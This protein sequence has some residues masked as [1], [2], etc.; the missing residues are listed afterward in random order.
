MAEQRPE[1]LQ[2]VFLEH[3]RSKA[4]PVT[5]FLVNGIK[6]QGYITY[7]DAYSLELT[8]AGQ[9]QVVYKGAISTIMPGSPVQL[10]QDE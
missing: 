5:I 7:F 6:L 8:R 9:T 4:V 2:N 10:S 3:V 1:S